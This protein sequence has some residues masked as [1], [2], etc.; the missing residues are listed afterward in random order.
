LWQD[1]AQLLTAPAL[2]QDDLV[3]D[4]L[5]LMDQLGLRHA[6]WA[7]LGDPLIAP[8]AMDEFRRVLAAAAAN[9][10]SE[11]KLVKVAPT[12]PGIEIRKPAPGVGLVY[13]L[14]GT[15]GYAIPGRV[16]LAQV[17][18]DDPQRLPRSEAYRPQPFEVLPGAHAFHYSG[19]GTARWNK[20]L[21]FT[22]HYEIPFDLIL[23][24]PPEEAGEMVC[25]LVK[26]L[27]EHIRGDVRSA[28]DR[29]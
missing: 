29:R 13:V 10:K 21:H 25:S 22:R 23:S 4:F 2:A 7:G 1:F 6:D 28:F 15:R 27:L 20:N 16:V 17:G 19:S 18:V 12:N 9:L 24:V 3:Q 11:A 26:G 14:F 5:E 8:E